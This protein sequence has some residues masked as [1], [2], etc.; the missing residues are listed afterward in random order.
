M[1][2]DQKVVEKPGSF[3]SALET[4]PLNLTQK[5]KKRKINSY[6]KSDQ[7]RRRHLTKFISP[8][9][10]PFHLT[11][12]Y[13]TEKFSETLQRLSEY[14]HEKLKIVNIVTANQTKNEMKE[15][16]ISMQKQF[17]Q[18]SLTLVKQ[19]DSMYDEFSILSKSLM[20]VTESLLTQNNLCRVFNIVKDDLEYIDDPP[21]IF[22]ELKTLKEDLKN[23]NEK[24]K[25]MQVVHNEYEEEAL[26]AKQKVEFADEELEK[27]KNNHE[28]LKMELERK[29]W[30]KEKNVRDEILQLGASFD[31]YK[32]K[33][34]QELLVRTM[35]EK[36]Q[37]DFIN[38]LMMELKNMKMVLQHP[39][40]RMKTYER[41]KECKS[42]ADISTTL[43]KLSIQ[44]SPAESFRLN[45]KL[46]V[47]YFSSRSNNSTQRTKSS[48]KT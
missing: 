8:T 48:L 9:P 7:M 21:D 29:F 11:P 47:G 22:A 32:L 38:E 35:V 12:N 18:H 13:S 15:S 40:L 42:P 6:T 34:N 5:L 33:I 3:W 25:A 20:S 44:N 45:S 1:S 14:K 10:E 46:Y 31:A 41:L 36:R 37:Q 24:S 23:L 27:I 19:R 39:T 26:K 30:V 28:G 16:I 4:I 43:P 17:I 2:A